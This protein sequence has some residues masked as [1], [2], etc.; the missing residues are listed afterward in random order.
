MLSST[1]LDVIDRIWKGTIKISVR[2]S[3][4][5]LNIHHHKSP[6]YYL[7]AKRNSFLPL[8]YD[9]FLKFFK[10]Y[11][12]FATEQ[13]FERLKLNLW[14]E[15]EDIPIKWNYPIGLLYDYLGLDLNAHVWN[16]KIHFNNYPTDFLIPQIKL[17]FME[18]FWVN[19]IKEACYI[20]HSSAKPIMSLSTVDSSS[21]WESVKAHDFSQFN[22][23]FYKKILPPV[24]TDLK[25]V[26]VKVY[27]PY[28][29][30][31]F[32]LQELVEP[33]DPETNL[34]ITIKD[35]LNKWLPDL[36]SKNDPN[37]KYAFPLIQG[38]I[39]PGNVPICELYYLM[40]YLDGF[41]HIC[42]LMNS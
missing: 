24:S 40:T 30:S 12:N 14:L 29:S 28:S 31:N 6:V 42:I 15:F 38:I 18:K 10:P 23:I 37:Y 13:T 35:V 22:S 20:Q 33:K 39:V 16:L 21:L 27:L 19:Q 25:H 4:L 9:D 41:L 3:P 5:D 7:T 32:I 26:P 8:Y 11:L 2:L 17:D 1:D 36:F 34:K